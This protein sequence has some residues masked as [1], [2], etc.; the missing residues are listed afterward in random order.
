M[1]SGPDSLITEIAPIP[2]GVDRAQIV[3]FFDDKVYEFI[4]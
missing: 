1:A 2:G 3:S 4:V